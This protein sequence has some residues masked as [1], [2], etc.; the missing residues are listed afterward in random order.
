MIPGKNAEAANLIC[1]P[2]SSS[3][4]P[5]PSRS[6]SGQ[7]RAEACIGNR[8]V[9]ILSLKVADAFRHQEFSD[10]QG[11]ISIPTDA[12]GGANLITNTKP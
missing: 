9:N 12:S 4:K 6:R 11:V 10:D 1:L 8:M 5:A 3:P 7:S 2:Q